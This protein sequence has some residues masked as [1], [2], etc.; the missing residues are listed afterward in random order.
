MSFDKIK[1]GIVNYLYWYYDGLTGQD[2]LLVKPVKPYFRPFSFFIFGFSYAAAQ[3]LLANQGVYFLHQAING[4]SEDAKLRFLLCMGAIQLIGVSAD[5]FSN[6]HH[7]KLLTDL[8]SSSLKTTEK[9]I[10]AVCEQLSMNYIDN[11]YQCIKT[12]NISALVA[13]T[14]S[15]QAVMSLYTLATV[16]SNSDAALFESLVLVKVASVASQFIKLY[17]DTKKQSCQAASLLIDK[18]IFELQ[19]SA[20][21]GEF[22]SINREKNGIFQRQLDALLAKQNTVLSDIERYDKINDIFQFTTSI[23][24]AYSIIGAIQSTEKD[25]KNFTDLVFE[26]QSFVNSIISATRREDKATLNDALS[27][28]TILSANEGLYAVKALNDSQNTNDVNIDISFTKT[29]FKDS[30][31]KEVT[32]NLKYALKTAEGKM[33]PSPVLKGPNGTGKSCILRAIGGSQM[34]RIALLSNA[35]Y[36]TTLSNIPLDQIAYI[37]QGEIKDITNLTVYQSLYMSSAVYTLYN[38]LI[39]G[40][41]NVLSINSNSSE[42]KKNAETLKKQSRNSVNIAKITPFDVFTAFLTPEQKEKHA[43]GINKECIRLI[44]ALEIAIPFKKTTEGNLTLSECVEFNNP[45]GGEQ[46]KIKFIMMALTAMYGKK[47]LILIDEL[48]NDLDDKSCR[49]IEEEFIKLRIDRPTLNFISVDH[50]KE[51]LN[52]DLY[53]DSIELQERAIESHR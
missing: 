22:I 41:T 26:I 23:F 5:N 29:V 43:D 1:Q 9:D 21:K 6:R 25:S 52:Q 33:A 53:S 45:S 27:V 34:N 44:Q 35:P 20:R 28:Y 24:Y 3:S 31:Y 2:A 37:P 17:I 14:N 39:L 51:P 10:G 7:R 16:L 11:V 50:R 42:D 49:K 46:K 36:T 15:A 18:K 13:G 47:K 38:A 40:L 32:A 48:Y 19:Q 4:S 8:Q 12:Y 30:V